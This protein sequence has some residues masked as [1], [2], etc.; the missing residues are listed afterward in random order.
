M[1]GKLKAYAEKYLTPDARRDANAFLSDCAHYGRGERRYADRHAQAENHDRR[2]KICPVAAANVWEREK[3]EADHDFGYEL[4][5]R[6]AQIMME[7]LQAT[8]IQLL[9]MYNVPSPLT[10]LERS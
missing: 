1:I 5:K 4:V 3:G 10:P 2:E 9:D 6:V 7:R 8:R